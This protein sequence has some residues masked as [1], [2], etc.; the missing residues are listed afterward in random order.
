MFG[1][2]IEKTIKIEG[3]SCMHCVKKVE[4]ALKSIAEIKSVKVDLKVAKI[5]LKKEIE[6]SI[7]EEA[8]QEAGFKVVE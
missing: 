8:V 1:N 7:I 6:N 3:M 4:Q 5:I 2:K